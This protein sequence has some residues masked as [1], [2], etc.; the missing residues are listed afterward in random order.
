MNTKMNKKIK[1]TLLATLCCGLLATA[2]AG[3]MTGFNASADSVRVK[4]TGLNTVALTEEIN[5]ADLDTFQ[6]YGASTGKKELLGFRFLATIEQSD[7]ALIPNTAEFG[8]VIIPNRLLGEGELTVDTANALVAPALIDTAAA[9]VPADGLGYYITLMGETLQAA[10]PEGLYDTALTARAYVKYTYTANGEEITDYVYSADAMTRS[11]AYVASRELTDAENA[12]EDVSGMTHLNNVISQT[13]TEATLTLGATEIEVGDTTTATLNGATDGVNDYAYNLKSSKET[14]ATINENGEIVAVGGGTTTITANIGTK[15]VST[16]L[17]VNGEK[18]SV[19]FTAGNIL[20]STQDGEIFMPDGLLDEGETVVSAVGTEDGVDYFEKGKWTALGLT[21]EEN[22]LNSTRP[23]SLTVETSEG[24]LYN[25]NSLSYAGV[26]DELSDFPKFFNNTAVPS[27]YD[28]TTYPAVAPNVY[29]YYIVTK[30]LGDGTDE[31]ALTQTEATDYQKT[32]G[33]NG[34]LDGAGHTLKFKLTSGGLVGMILGNAVIKN[35]AI[36]YEDG[37]YDSTTKKGGYGVLGYMTN[38]APEIRNSY[39]ERTN[40]LYHQG[41]VFGIMSRPNAKLILHNTAVHANNTSNQSGWYSNMWINETSTDAYL[42]YARAAAT[43]WTNVTNF[44]E[45]VTGNTLTSDLS[46]FDTNY[47]T[48]TNNQLNWKGL[49]DM[50]VSVYDATYVET[51]EEKAYYSTVSSEMILPEGLLT[52]G[53]TIVDA[54]DESGNDYYENGAW[55]NVALTADEIKANATKDVTLTLETSEGYFYKVS[56]GSYAGVIDELSDFPKFFDN[57]AVASEYDAATYPAVAPNVYGYYIVTKDLGSYTGT[58]DTRVFADELTLTQ[59]AATDYQKTNGFNGVLDGQGHTLKFKLMSGGLVGL[60]LGNATIQNIAVIYEDG[61]FISQSEGGGYGVFGYITNGSPVIKNSYIERTNNVSS[62]ST[63]WGIMARPNGKLQLNN[64]VVNGYRVPNDCTWWSNTVISSASTN[65]YVIH[66]R[67]NAASQGM[68]TNFTKVYT[69]AIENGSL[70]V[71]L[72]DIEDASGFDDRYWSKE[73]GKLIW[74]GFETV[75][76]SWV[77]GDTT[78]VEPVTKGGAIAIPTLPSNMYWSEVEDGSSALSSTIKVNADVTYYAI[79]LDREVKEKALY[80]TADREFFLPDTMGLNMSEISTITSADG[81]TVYYENGAWNRNFALSGDQINANETM[82][83]AIKVYDGTINY[84]VTVVSYA[85]VI[86]ELS[87]FPKFFNNTAVTNTADNAATYPTVAPNTYGYYI[88]TKDLGTTADELAFTQTESTNYT[89]TNGFNGILDGQGHKVQFKLMSG[90]L[91]GMVLGNCTIQNIAIVYEDGTYDSTAKTGGYGVFGYITNGAPV[92]KNSYIERTNNLYHQGSVFG[93]MARPNVKLTLHNTA[94]HANNTSNTSGWYSNMWISSAS[95]NAYLIYARAEATGW[96]NVTNFTEVTTTNT[97]TSDLSSFDTNYW[98]TG[99]S[100]LS[101]KGMTGD[102]VSSLGTVT[103]TIKNL[104]E[105]SATEYAIVL[106]TNADATLTTA[107]DELISFFAEATGATLS[108]VSDG[109]YDT[110]ETYISIGNTQTFTNANIALGDINSQGYHIERVNNTIYINGKSS[111]GCLYGVYGL[112]ENLFGFEQFSEDT[113]TLKTATTVAATELNV[114]DSP[115]FEMHMPSNG[116]LIADATYR[117]RMRMAQS[118]NELFFQVGDYVLNANESANTGWRVWHNSLEILPYDY[119]TNGTAVTVKHAEAKPQTPGTITVG[120]SQAV[121]SEDGLTTTYTPLDTGLSR[122]WFAE[123]GN[124]L[125]YTAQGDS[126]AYQAMVAEIVRVMSIT[127]TSSQITNRP[128]AIYLTLTSEDGNGVCTCEACK[129]AKNTYGSDVGAVIKLCNDV[130]AGVQTWMEEN[131]TYKRDNVKVLFFA[132]NDY[133]TAPTAGTIEMREDVAVMYAISH[134]VNF[135]YDVYEPENDEFRAQFE[136]WA[137]LTAINNSDFCVWT[138]TKNF[139][140]YMLRADVYGDYA[141]FNEQAYYYFA[142]NGVDLW[143]NQGATDGTSTLSAFEKLNGYI[144]SKIMWN[145]E[146][147]VGT[148][149]DNWFAA[150][151]GAGADDMFSLYEAQNAAARSVF[152]ITTL[153]IPTVAMDKS[154]AKDVLTESVLNTWF[155][156]IDSAKSAVNADTSLTD[157]EKAKLI[158]HINEEWISVKFL[159]VYLYY[160]SLLDGLD[161]VT[162]DVDTAKAEFREVLGY[163]SATGTY[164]KD[165]VL[166]EKAGCTLV[167][168]I[169]SDFEADV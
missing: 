43:G 79:S 65:A 139:A 159:Y 107:K 21:D 38:G 23:T 15:T 147:E 123:S 32:N 130:S 7:L 20:Y 103:P 143:F 71:L 102:A 134:Y 17:T 19:A 86:D 137:A 169:E 77:N 35:I 47:W 151:Y 50:T 92:I 29:G 87:D 121:T 41:S 167:E 127:L 97:L 129:E 119:W 42:I 141:F 111:L 152:G 1:N 60:V 5:D 33:F 85:G 54:K 55:Q 10:F 99:N 48:T 124:Q 67:A 128:D 80:S 135:H 52:D 145:S 150:M 166:R 68:A 69:D 40:N 13:T 105:D 122:K 148:L 4:P 106:P 91:V 100:Q 155:G 75:N 28:A 70:E 104:V 160:S 154:S 74:K 117:N 109:S 14:V 24:D 113:Y 61:S 133:V 142:E 94:V 125:C 16:P 88:V 118:E 58:G 110:Y 126:V 34:V 165:V 168:W 30:D 116:A 93:I 62:R 138:Y 101:W 114:T 136:A 31:L 120:Q 73:G 59:T 39:I 131:P 164:A 149:I 27:E 82:E 8:T 44:T 57:T 161:G 158:G 115:D 153:G 140:M 53:E 108:V 90:G 132:Y 83:T 84:Y 2:G 9:E 112:L 3:V 36:I 6:V 144:D 46:T 49:D 64:T 22:K 26:I 81:E 146:N 25:V 163:D 157:E 37:T 12:G 98:N 162:V 78:T 11:I 96:P 95:T 45:V 156:Y 63:V 66:G 56:V 18:M 76:V 89:A 72:S 51:V